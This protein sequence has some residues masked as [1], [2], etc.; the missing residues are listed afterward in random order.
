MNDRKPITVLCIGGP[1]DG[2]DQLAQGSRIIAREYLPLAS[3]GPTT[4]FRDVEYT[5]DRIGF[6][7]GT[8]TFAH[9][10]PHARD[11]IA[12]LMAC[13]KVKK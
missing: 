10:F 9:C 7:N 11:A 12:Y 1:L 6:G 13:H 3:I 2:T 8:L 5:I 4:S